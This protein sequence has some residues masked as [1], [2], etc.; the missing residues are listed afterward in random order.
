MPVYSFYCEKC[1]ADWPVMMSI[2]EREEELK[3]PDCDTVLKR[4]LDVPNFI[5]R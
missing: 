1:D 3:C 4:I 2:A 5:I